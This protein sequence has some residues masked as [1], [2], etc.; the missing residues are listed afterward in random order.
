[1]TL[2]IYVSIPED[3]CGDVETPEL[4]ESLDH[5][6]DLITI[7]SGDYAEVKVLHVEKNYYEGEGLID[8]F[9]KLVKGESMWWFV[10]TALREFQTLLNLALDKHATVLI[11]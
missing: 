10:Q 2:N 7:A 8:N 5:L 11:A 9:D 3:T 6:L 1:M 4:A